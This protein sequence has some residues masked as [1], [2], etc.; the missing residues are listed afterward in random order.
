MTRTQ[1]HTRTYMRS[2][3]PSG[4]SSVVAP[5]GCVVLRYGNILEDDGTTMNQFGPITYDQG[6]VFIL[7]PSEGEQVYQV[8]FAYHGLQHVWLSG[9]PHDASPPP[10]TMLTAHKTNSGVRDSGRVTTDNALLNGVVHA[11]RMS[12]TDVLQSIGMDVPD[13]ERLGWLGDVSQYSEAAMRMLDM[14]AFFQN[15]LRNEVDTAALQGGWL[16]S[17]APLPFHWSKGDPAW[18]SALPGI[19]QHL[20]QETGD[21]AVLRRVYGTVVTQVEQYLDVASHNTPPLLGSKAGGATYVI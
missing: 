1:T 2:N 18:V 13:R 15:Q 8:H 12:V 16:S 11:A 6:D 3:V 20:Y 21:D 19:A 4:M 17:I 7:G 9:L 14:T 10:L 5:F